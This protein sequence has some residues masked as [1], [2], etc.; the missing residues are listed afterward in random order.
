MTQYSIVKTGGKQYIA[1]TGSSIVVDKLE[2]SIGSTVE[3]ETLA[4]F[5]EGGRL[6]LGT[7]SLSKS[8][9]ATIEETG[10]GEKV[11]IAKFKAKVRYRRVTGFRASLTKLKIV[12]V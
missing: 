4:R 9:Q 2:G 3:L 1:Q 7:P 5:E 12:S 8:T 10:K 11:R 6:E